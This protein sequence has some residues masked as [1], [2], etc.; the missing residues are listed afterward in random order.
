[1]KFDVII[2]NPPYQLSDG[3]NNASAIPIYNK[4][5]E[6]AKKLNPKYL[7]MIIPSRWYCG[8]RGLDTFRTQMLSD[9]HLKELHDYK[10][11]SDCFPGIR[12]GGGVCYFLWDKSYNSNIARI[13]EHTDCDIIT[14][15]RRP[16]NEFGDDI[17]IR[18]S[19]AC[20]II[21]KILSF[22]E[23]KFS[24]YVYSQKP[25][26]IR[27][28]FIDFD[29]DGELKIYTKKS[30]DGFSYI[31][32]SKVTVN[33]DTISKWKVVTSRSTSVPEEDNGQVLR[34][35]QTF[36]VEPNA[37]VTESYVMLG[38]FNSEEEAKNCYSYIRTR[39]FRF[40]CQPLIV[41]P[42]VS[43]RT[44]RFVPMQDFSKPWTDKELYDKYDLTDEQISFIESMIRF[45]D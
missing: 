42:D 21:R 37:V 26:G 8:G 13:V 17:F 6:Q 14:D 45:I 15:V 32:K 11:S 20:E 1:M 28:N 5:V 38:V 23:E 22:K 39:F 2:G 30:K 36:I 4:F 35:S 33:I 27:T 3:G 9:N 25:Y 16:L 31:D 40:L 10:K 19:N 18:D 29:K 44:F 41:S 34:M 7:A 43:K 12:N 24:D